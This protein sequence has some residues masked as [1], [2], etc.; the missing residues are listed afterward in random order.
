[1]QSKKLLQLWTELPVRTPSP[2]LHVACFDPYIPN[3]V[4]CFG[5]YIREMG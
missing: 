2:F 1:M 3:D 5:P 4:A